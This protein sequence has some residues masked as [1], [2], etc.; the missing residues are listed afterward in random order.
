MTIKSLFE[1]GELT[2]ALQTIDS[3]DVNT[4]FQNTSQFTKIG[5][6]I[7]TNQIFDETPKNVSS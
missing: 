5:E 2:E 4:S 6:S 7:D 1:A 3:A